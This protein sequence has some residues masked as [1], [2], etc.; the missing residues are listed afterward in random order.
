[1]STFRPSFNEQFPQFCPRFV[2]VPGQP[3]AVLAYDVG[4]NLVWKLV[5]TTGS[6]VATVVSI[7]GDIQRA[8]DL[9]VSADG[10]TFWVTGGCE[11]A[12][13]AGV[14]AQTE[15]HTHSGRSSTP[16]DR[17][18]SLSLDQRQ[19]RQ[20]TSWQGVAHEDTDVMVLELT[21]RDIDRDIEGC[22]PRPCKA[23]RC[24]DAER[25][26]S[27]RRLGRPSVPESG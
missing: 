4:Q 23:A 12:I 18:T 10:S 26:T 15:W 13:S 8:R 7:S 9:V 17:P 11:G 16:P 27:A 14:D 6:P 21:A 19:G 22:H 5:A 24:S 3:T 2:P 1:V 20:A 25:T